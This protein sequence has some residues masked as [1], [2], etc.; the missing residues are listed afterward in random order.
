MLSILIHAFDFDS[1]FRFLSSSATLASD[2]CFRF[3][4]HAFEF[5]FLISMLNTV[6]LHQ[7]HDYRRK[8]NHKTIKTISDFNFWI[9]QSMLNPTTPWVFK[10]TVMIF[11]VY[12]DIY[13]YS[14]IPHMSSRLS[15]HVI[16]PKM[17]VRVWKCLYAS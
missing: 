2:S 4:I 13:T 15:P 3:L 10:T 7:F 1:C 12:N 11:Y 16:H 17:I 9:M 6:L 5:R 8:Q 14:I